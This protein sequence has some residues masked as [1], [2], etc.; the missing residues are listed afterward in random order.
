MSGGGATSG[1]GGAATSDGIPVLHWKSG[2]FVGDE[3]RALAPGH[4][5]IT[6]G[7]LTYDSLIVIADHT[8]DVPDH[9]HTTPNHQHATP[10]HTHPNH[11]HTIPAHN[12]D[13]TY[14]I[15]EEDTSPTIKFSVSQDNGVSYSKAYGN[16]PIDQELL[17]ITD[18]ITRT[19]SKILKFEATTRTR[20]TVQI[21]VKVDISVR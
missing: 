12:H 9:Q 4:E 8:H 17:D 15:F 13:I 18:S 14:G 1:S 11:Q 20:L 5:D 6:H 16:T 21:E 3:F 10:A 19:G 7:I 2:E